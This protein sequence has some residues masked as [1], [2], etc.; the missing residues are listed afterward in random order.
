[1]LCNLIRALSFKHL[2]HLNIIVSY[3]LPLLFNNKLSLSSL[4]S[5]TIPIFMTMSSAI[6]FTRSLVVWSF[7]ILLYDHGSPSSDCKYN[8]N[9]ENVWLCN[10]YTV[11]MTLILSLKI[12]VTNKMKIKKI[13]LPIAFN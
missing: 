1:M 9:V 3:T 7:S 5:P 11:Q 12:A 2:H 8:E 4:N 10:R 13:N 6:N